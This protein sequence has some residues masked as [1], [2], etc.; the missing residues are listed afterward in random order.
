MNGPPRRG[1]VHDRDIGHGGDTE[2]APAGLAERDIQLG[3]VPCLE[4]SY[5]KRTF[6]R[7]AAHRAVRIGHRRRLRRLLHRPRPRSRPRGGGVLGPFGRCFSGRWRT[8]AVAGFT[9]PFA[10]TRRSSLSRPRSRRTARRFRSTRRRR[11]A[12]KPSRGGPS[13]RTHGFGSLGSDL[14][15][16][17]WRQS[18]ISTRP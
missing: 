18:S 6:E 16:M 1:A 14:T 4:P 8:A 11:Q 13:A 10:A 17:L 5:T 3:A 15:A 7:V 9:S 2:A 12:S